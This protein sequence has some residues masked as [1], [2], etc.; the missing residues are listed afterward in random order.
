MN[1]CVGIMQGQTPHTRIIPPSAIVCATSQLCTMIQ[2]VTLA[3]GVLQNEASSVLYV[4]SCSSNSDRRM[5]IIVSAMNQ[6]SRCTFHLSAWPGDRC[7]V[8]FCWP[9]SDHVFIIIDW[10]TGVNVTLIRCN[11]VE[12]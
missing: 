10:P 12:A 2:S 3:V 9:G 5:Y 6:S 11:L 4:G 7:F 8:Y 1:E